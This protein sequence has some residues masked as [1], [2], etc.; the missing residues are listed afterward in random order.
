MTVT[1]GGRFMTRAVLRRLTGLVLVTLMV[2][3]C[4]RQPTAVP[5]Y[6]EPRHQPVLTLPDVRVLDVNL[7]PN[8]TSLYH[9]HAH[10]I[11][12]AV[13]EGSQVWAQTPAGDTVGGD[14][15]TG[16]QGDNTTNSLEPVTHRV[17]NRGSTHF[18]LIAIENLSAPNTSV[19]VEFGRMSGLGEP[20]VEDHRFRAWRHTLAPGDSVAAHAHVYPAMLLMFSGSRVTVK[21]DGSARTLHAGEWLWYASASD[22]T[23]QNTG[24]D[25]AVVSTIEVR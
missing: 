24:P 8:D 7:P 23:F 9:I 3:A 5:V 18:R 20:E 14:W 19:P 16:F 4:Q 6:M 15:G 21:S 2:T 13:V 22:H 25:S 10:D 12:Y 17:G 11:F 1:R